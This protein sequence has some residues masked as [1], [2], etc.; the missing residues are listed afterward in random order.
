MPLD[1][2]VTGR[3]ATFAGAE[4]FG[5]VEA[6][7]IRGGRVAFA[8]SAVELETRADPHT[9]RLELDP[10]EL[11]IPGLTDA[12]LH[13]ADAAIAAADLDLSAAPTLEHGLA[14]IAERHA[15]LPEGAW[16]LGH[17]WSLDRWAGW[18]TA[19]ELDRVAPGRRVALWAHDHH[20]IWASS[21]AL[22]RAGVGAGM[23]DPPGGLIRRDATGQPTGILQ[24][25]AARLVTDILPEPDA[26][27]IAAALPRLVGQLHALGVVAVHDPCSLGED[28]RLERAWAAYARLDEAGRLG[29]RVHACLRAGSLAAA[30]AG[31]WRSGAPLSRAPDPLARV[32]WLKLFAD[33][34]LGSRTAALLEPIEPDPEAPVPA[35]Q[36]RGVWTMEPEELAARADEAA[37]GGI[38]GQIHAIGDAAVR[39]S[40][41]ALGPHAGNTALMPRVEHSQLIA[42]ADV[43][44]FGALGIAASVQPVH[45]RTDAAAAR[46]TWGGRAE[47][48]GYAW[49]RLL[50]SGATLAF[51][52]DAPVE[53]IDPWPGI[54]IAVARR[55]PSWGAG[56]AP[57]GPAEALSLA[58]SLRA[59]CVGPATTERDPGRGRLV[60]GQSAD[61]IVLPA[62]PEEAGPGAFA[63]VRPRLTMLRGRIVHE[64]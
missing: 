40:L 46:R 61:L 37:A 10:G 44:R 28:P 17:G 24:E 18:P 6:I 26:D 16:L 55:D 15:A 59:A 9:E 41:D 43:A 47:A 7:G 64:S 60:P 42:P 53:P 58:E 36:E 57:F 5:W 25:N 12:H 56:A 19:S 1:A 30:V 50:D 33:G 35:G 32:G 13:L 48:H 22:E 34:T 52:T 39:A 4:G 14:A 38:T 11:A 23:A 45:L 2:L 8:G 29:L 20:A 63:T 27:A 49:R 62:V 21:V 3:I 31:G 51:G 54:A